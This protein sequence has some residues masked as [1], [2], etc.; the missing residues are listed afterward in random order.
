M[1]SIVFFVL[2]SGILFSCNNDTDTRVENLQKENER[3]RKETQDKDSTINSFFQSYNS[4]EENLATIKERENILNQQ[5][6]SGEIDQGSSERIN[7]D[8]QLINDLIDQ[9]KKT[10][11]VLRKKLKDSNMQGGEMQKAIELLTAQIEEKDAE[12][13]ALKNKLEEMDIEI[14]TL[15]TTVEYQE[16]LLA[17]QSSTIEAKEDALNTAWYVFGTEKELKKNGII[18]KEGGF[19]GIGKT[20]KLSRDF[21]K[22]YFTQVDIRNLES[23]SLNSRRVRVVTTHPAGSYKLVGDKTIERIDITDAKQFWSASKYLVIVVK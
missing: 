3:L 21:N 16:G 22:K 18:S 13:V 2:L 6:Q 10:I 15:S 23:I 7:E 8:I 17:D 1:R 20:R 5:V 11:A 4:I 19:I 14:K 9:N 12:I